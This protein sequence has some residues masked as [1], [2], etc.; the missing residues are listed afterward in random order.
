MSDTRDFYKLIRELEDQYQVNDTVGLHDSFDLELNEHFVIE[1]GIVGLAE[2]GII[3]QLDE[4]A[5]EF[6]DFNGMLTETAYEDDL[7]D[8][9][10][11]KVEGVYGVKS[12]PFSRKFKNKAA[13]D[14]FFD[15]PDNE[16]NYEIRYVSK[17]SE[18]KGLS[19]SVE[20]SD[21]FAKIVKWDDAFQVVDDG[22]SGNFGEEARMK[23]QDMYD[24]VVID[25]GFHPDDDIEEIIAHM[26]D[27]IWNSRDH[28]YE[29]SQ[30]EPHDKDEL[31]EIKNLALGEAEYQGRK[32]TLN[33]PMQGDVAKS[34]VYVKKPDGKVVKVNFG[35]K[36]MRIKKS[37]PARRKSFRA[38]HRCENPGPKWKARYWSCRAW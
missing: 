31:S 7:E 14:K 16:G 23:L 28:P 3:I 18:S 11:R 9:E 22:L 2:D 32:V 17:V 15:H 25:H 1:S 26:I 12:K 24:D 35:D 30:Q 34:K 38:R 20:D 37:N 13:M 4:E 36:D 21:I 19:E 27:I 10:P 5:L 8:T 33:K 6:L 29:G